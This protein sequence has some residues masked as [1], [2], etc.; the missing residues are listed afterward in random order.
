[1]SFTNEEVRIINRDNSIIL[2][3]LL[4]VNNRPEQTH[5][6]PNC[7]QAVP[8]PAPATVNRRRQEEGILKDNLV[9]K[10]YT[11]GKVFFSYARK[12]MFNGI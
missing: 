12:C 3:K 8:K 5:S 9:S 2:E 10:G 6:N 11:L 7:R 4:A 1:M